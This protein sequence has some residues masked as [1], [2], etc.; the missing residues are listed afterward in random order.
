[1]KIA[2]PSHSQSASCHDPVLLKFAILPSYGVIP[3]APPVRK[4]CRWKI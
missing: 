3:D 2:Y 1:M 4:N